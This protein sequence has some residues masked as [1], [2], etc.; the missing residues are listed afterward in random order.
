MN[1]AVTVGTQYGEVGRNVVFDPHPFFK[2]ANR[3]E[4]MRLNEPLS[5]LTVT[6]GKIK[7][8]GLASRAME[9]F[10]LT[11]CSAIS[12]DLSMKRVFPFLDNC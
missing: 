11:R 6:L 3:F 1:H 5:D 8:T 10:S 9:F 4:M 12:F 7:R 2:F